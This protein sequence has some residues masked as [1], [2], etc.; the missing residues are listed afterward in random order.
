MVRTQ[1]QL[2]TELYQRAKSLAD[3][4]EIS[5]AELMRRGLEAILSQYSES[6]PPADQWRLPTADVGKTYVD[7]DDLRAYATDDE[8]LRS[9]VAET[10]E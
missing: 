9:L 6:T 3:R 7:L 2:P 1:I 5:L 10:E 4:R 8:A